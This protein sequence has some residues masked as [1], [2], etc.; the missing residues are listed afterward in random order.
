MTKREIMLGHNKDLELVIITP[1]NT[2]YEGLKKN[3]NTFEEYKHNFFKNYYFKYKNA[4]INVILSPQGLSTQDIICLFNNTTILFIGLAGALNNN[5]KIGQIVEVSKSVYD[6]KI[7]LR[8]LN[9]FEKV[10]CGYSPCMLGEL[11]KD[12]QDNARKN[13]CD[14]IDMETYY[15]ARASLEFNNNFSSLL[16]IT[17]IPN[18]I[19][20]WEISDDESRLINESKNI[21]IKNIETILEKIREV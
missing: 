16:I 12:F 9:T 18:I 4:Y 10:T 8:E 5:L 19:N 2:I 7:N 3:N 15:C 14:V 17:D 11:S 6:E 21:I 13:N 1:S 20:F